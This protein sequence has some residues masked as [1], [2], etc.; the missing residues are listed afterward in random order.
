MAILQ[1]LLS[2]PPW[3]SYHDFFFLIAKQAKHEAQ[4]EHL[5]N[6]SEWLWAPEEQQ[7]FLAEQQQRATVLT[8]R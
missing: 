3:N 1:N 5:K 8:D 4:Q 2:L 6:M 7:W